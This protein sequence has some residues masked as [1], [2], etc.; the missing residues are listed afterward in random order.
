M[1]ITGFPL[2]VI[3]II[4]CGTYINCIIKSVNIRIE[5]ESVS[6]FFEGPISISDYCQRKNPFPLF[7]IKTISQMQS[8]T[9]TNPNVFTPPDINSDIDYDSIDLSDVFK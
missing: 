3:I 1:L 9:I 6:S 4:A 7:I 5:R 2:Y 8:I